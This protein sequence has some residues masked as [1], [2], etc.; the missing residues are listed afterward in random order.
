MNKYRNIALACLLYIPFGANAQNEVTGLV[1]DNILVENMT[2]ARTGNSL[3]VDMDLNMDKL[4]M[5]SNQRVVLTPVVK[6]GVNAVTMPSLILNG[7]KQQISYKRYA[8]RKYPAGV[9]VVRRKNKTAQTYHYNAVLPA[10]EWMNN[11]NV[12]VAEDLCGC[13]GKVEG[14]EQTLVHRLRKPYMAYLRP[15][16]EAVKARHE[17]GRAFVDFPVDQTTLY[18]DY[19]E[20]P[21]ELK[22]IVETI[23]LVKNDK[24]TSITSISIHG[25]AS[26]EAPYDHNAY[27]A[28]N[29]ANTLKNYVRQLVNLE[30]RVFTVKSTPEDWDGLESWVE[31]S[32]LTN[33]RA[34]LDIMADPRYSNPDQREW[35]IKKEYPEDYKTMLQTVYPALRHS[36]YVV[37][38]TVRAFSVE[39]AKELLKTKPQQLSLEEMYLVAQ[40]YEPGSDDFNEVFETAVRMFPNDETANLN[41]ACTRIESGDYE[42][43]AKYLKKAGD[44]AYANHARGVIAMRQGKDAEAR[45]FFEI[46]RNGGV[47]AAEKNL[48]ILQMDADMQ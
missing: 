9:Q 46:A 44:S 45:R 40:T 43:A 30:D 38:Y 39:E 37:N 20:N 42:A 47:E 32:N 5:R 15:Q 10:E 1:S 28:E 7:R 13:A 27:L 23:N 48:Q 36:D 21:R 4:E 29:R 26:P 41:A 6:D 2:V 3:V 14:Q 22:K 34:I 11:A 18:P 33:R 12:M 17:E 16:A 19:R 24:N 35:K 31:K 25:Y 8:H